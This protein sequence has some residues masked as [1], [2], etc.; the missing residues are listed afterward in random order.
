LRDRFGIPVRLNF[1]TVEELEQV[2]RRAARL[3]NAPTTGEGEHEIAR[4]SRCTP[5]HRRPPAAPRARLRP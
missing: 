1:Y 3:L 5:Q 2:V 4:R